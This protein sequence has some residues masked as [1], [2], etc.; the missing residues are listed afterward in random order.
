VRA[1]LR[2]V[3]AFLVRHPRL[4]REAS[5]SVD[6]LVAL[7]R[8]TPPGL[9][10]A[11]ADVPEVDVRTLVVALVGVQE[12]A[13]TTSLADL[14][15]A[16][17]LHGALR[18]VVAVPGEHLAAVR[19]AGMVAEHLARED[20]WDERDGPWADHVAA[21]LRTAREDYRADGVVARGASGTQGVPP[22]ALAALVPPRGRG[23]LRRLGSR[24]TWRVER[25]LDAPDR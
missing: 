2:A 10:G 13:L 6:A 4:R 19:R 21:L 5:R 15:A 3:R 23:R 25:T 16:A 20:E 1:L 22:Q 7:S 24:A 8:T 12:A 17:A 18:Y 11:P 9:R 14:R